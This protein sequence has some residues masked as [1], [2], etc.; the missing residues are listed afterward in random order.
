M[1]LQAAD[2]K[3]KEEET[4]LL[5]LGDPKEEDSFM[6]GEQDSMMMTIITITDVVQ[7]SLDPLCMMSVLDK[8]LSL[9]VSDI[10]HLV[11]SSP[12]CCCTIAR[13]TKR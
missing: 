6:A 11:P 3:E 10:F 7:V 9:C 8:T 2:L 1:F 12:L 4:D 5:M 13:L